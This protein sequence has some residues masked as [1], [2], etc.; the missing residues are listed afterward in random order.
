[1]SEWIARLRSSGVPELEGVGVLVRPHPQLVDQWQESIDDRNVA[2]WPNPSADLAGEDSRADY[3]ESF[4]HASAVVGINTSA[5]IEAAV[6]DRPSLTVLTPEYRETQEGTLHFAHLSE[7]GPLIVASTYDEHL[8]HLRRVLDGEDLDRDASRR[9]VAS[10]VRPLGTD[11]PAGEYLVD[12]VEQL[13]GAPLR[14]DQRAPRWHTLA[15]RL[16][17]PTAMDMQKTREKEREMSKRAKAE[18]VA[19]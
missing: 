14:R 4:R 2:V 3:F 15:R 16:L 11:R 19:A 5:F 10:F 8:D 9:F 13:A 17:R 7:G 12:A 18:K 6:M 1:V